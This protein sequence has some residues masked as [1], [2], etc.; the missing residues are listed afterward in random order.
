MEND[1]KPCNKKKDDGI[2]PMISIAYKY[3][4]IGHLGEKPLIEL[5]YRRS[6][7]QVQL[8]PPMISRG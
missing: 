3:N 5:T 6:L 2:Y 7:V 8:G 4:K 1:E